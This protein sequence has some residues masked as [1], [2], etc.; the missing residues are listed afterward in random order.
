MKGA[1]R[2]PLAGL[3][4]ETSPKV[5]APDWKPGCLICDRPNP[6]FG[7]GADLR[8]GNVGFW[9]CREHVPPNFFA[10]R[11]AASRNGRGRP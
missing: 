5:S 10:D 11:D 6:P 2:N 4:G 3:M 8:R 9:F 1:N 7:M